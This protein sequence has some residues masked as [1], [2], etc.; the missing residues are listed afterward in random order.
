MIFYLIG[1]DYKTSSLRE[2]ELAYSKRKEIAAFYQGLRPRGEVLFT[3]NRAEFYGLADKEAEI[4]QIAENLKIRYP[5]IFRKVYLKTN[6]IEVLKHA[7]RL[8]VGL[9]SQVLGEQQIFEQLKVWVGQNDFSEILRKFWDKVLVLSES[10]R[11]KSILNESE[12]GVAGVVLDEL[13]NNSN[14]DKYKGMVIIGTGRIARLFAE[15]RSLGSKLYF[16]SRKKHSKAKQFAKVSSGKVISLDELEDTLLKVDILISATASS[17]YI[18]QKNQLSRIVARRSSPLF[19]YDLALPRDID[20][21]VKNV[22]GIF[23]KDLGDLGNTF[24]NYN[25]RLKHHSQRAEFLISEV[26]AGAREE[27]NEFVYKNRNASKQ[28]CLK[29]G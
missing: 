8:G 24:K 17:H 14:L 19:I 3:C 10:I 15:Y 1:I 16:A 27:I 23:L 25:Q 6:Y 12:R 18:L 28:T 9:E 21:E 22:S 29:T 11:F 4:H 20:P 26:I 2:R 5:E 7:L 13:D